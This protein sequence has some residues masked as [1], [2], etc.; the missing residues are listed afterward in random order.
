MSTTGVNLAM[1]LDVAILGPGAIVYWESMQD[2]FQAIYGRPIPAEELNGHYSWVIA[3]REV[4]D[5]VAKVQQSNI[6]QGRITMVFR[7]WRDLFHTFGWLLASDGEE[8][9]EDS[10]PEYS[11][12]EGGAEARL[13]GALPPPQ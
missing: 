12:S 2:W 7:M 3:H 6:E 10:P 9:D 11:D 5:R 4:V 13:P 8:E 1:K